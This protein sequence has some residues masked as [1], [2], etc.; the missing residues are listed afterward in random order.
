MQRPEGGQGVRVEDVWGRN[1]L[2]RRNKSES[3]RAGAGWPCEAEQEGRGGRE[4][5]SGGIAPVD[6]RSR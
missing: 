5:E 1:V 3:P 4:W 6:R 2:H